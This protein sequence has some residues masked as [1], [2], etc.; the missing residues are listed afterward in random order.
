MSKNIREA[1]GSIC[2]F[3]A[4]VLLLIMSLI[5][6]FL[7]S[8][9]MAASK[10]YAQILLK[11][12]T[13][14]V[15]GDYYGPLFA[16]YSIMAIDSG[17]GNKKGDSSELKRKLLKYM[18]DNVWDYSCEEIHVT[19]MKHLLDET[20]EGFLVQ[21]AAYE[22]YA[23]AE[24]I[25]EEVFSRIKNLGDQKTITKIMEKKMG[26]EDELA[27][28]DKKTL[29]L[30]K[31]ID[32]VNLTLGAKT[33]S[34][35]GYDIETGFIKK[36][37]VGENSMTGTGINNPQVYEQLKDKYVNPVE[38]YKDYT[39]D[40]EIYAEKLYEIR[41][42]IEKLSKLEKE[43]ESCD[44]NISDIEEE[45]EEKE[46]AAD[47][48]TSEINEC[49][50]TIAKASKKNT[51]KNKKTKKE[52]EEKLKELESELETIEDE[53]ENLNSQLEE[54]KSSKSELETEIGSLEKKIADKKKTIEK[55]ADSLEKMSELFSGL[56]DDTSEMLE[57]VCGIVDDIAKKQEKV[58][59]LV[60]DFETVLKT[61]GPVLDD[62]LVS[63]FTE[64][65]EFMKAYVGFGNNKI[66]TTDF[67]S[68]KKTAEYDL[69]LLSEVDLEAFE[70]L[71]TDNYEGIVDKLER[72]EGA[73]DVFLKFSYSG[74]T[75]DYS[76]IQ[77]SA[78]ENKLV[79]EFEN[80]VSEG[81]LSLFL[82][83]DVKLSKNSMISELLPSLWYEVVQDDSELEPDG[84][85]EGADD[86]GGGELLTEADEGSGISDLADMIEDGIESMGDKLLSAMYLR[87]HFKS[88]RNRTTEG[89]TVL[90]YELEYV[91]SGFETDMANLSAAATKVMLLRL[92]VCMVYTL[93]QKDLK[94]QAQALA[95]S[96]M[97][98]TGL[99]FLITIVKYL[100]LFLWAAA[101]AVIETAA[102]MRGKKVPIIPDSNS[103]CLTLPELPLFA[104][105]VSEKADNFKESEVYLDYDDYLLV[106]LLMQGRKTQA[107]RAMDVI[108]EN[109]RY[110]YDDDFLISNAITAFSCDAVF[111]APHRFSVIAGMMEK[112]SSYN[113]EVSD[114]VAY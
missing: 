37:Y 108:Q 112:D 2:V 26:I 35:L 92:A 84:I 41:D 89:D 11:T 22:K 48:I 40:L 16:D 34:L 107:A 19:E 25:L 27:I 3:L 56:L 5:L 113:I 54:L 49:K 83:S 86:K 102:I 23:A 114:N 4:L 17:F 97:G 52:A 87:H 65:L 105:L 98:F 57:D 100:V 69:S 6:V 74:F 12:A 68:I 82:P 111:S 78:L 110:K 66:T 99:P 67:D 1:K 63:E 28:I 59:P 79:E 77:T 42:E 21:A 95:V 58:K 101:Q 71:D 61:L 18:G 80:N 104:T 20:G 72:M 45:L 43:K 73:D 81:Y 106:L 29:E 46:S 60:E 70:F 44:H 53:K 8:A 93:T 13:G 85:T 10:S 14:S 33:S 91:L 103:F 109:I 55:L 31:L 50:D 24:E 64:T 62:D 47:D 39:G 32:G 76:E 9:S 15:L 96:I 36:F 90:D 88:F 30:M 38:L 75:F 94:A 51:K 7:E